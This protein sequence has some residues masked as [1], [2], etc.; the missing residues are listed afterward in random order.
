LFDPAAWGSDRPL[1]PARSL[2]VA[3][4]IADAI[5]PALAGR[6]VGLHWPNDVFV[7]GRK[8]AGVLLDVLP[9]HRHVLGIGLNVNNRLAEAPPDVQARAT[10]LCELTG[11]THDRTELLLAL[12]ANIKDALH[13]TTEAP[14]LLGQRFAQL[15]LQV[16]CELTV[17]AAGRR[18]TGRCAGIADDGALLLT[19]PQGEQRIY[20]GR[21]V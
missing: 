3:V 7:D 15:C 13:L 9:D 20:S 11:Q 8:L 17:E 1:L 14:E 5:S 18:T 12:L 4:A 2:A 10:T 16:G 21:L 6:H 19:T